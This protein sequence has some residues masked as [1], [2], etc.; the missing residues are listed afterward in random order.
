[1]FT[2]IACAKWSYP[3]RNCSPSRRWQPNASAARRSPRRF[4]R[5]AQTWQTASY[6]SKTQRQTRDKYA[7][8]R[9]YTSHVT[10][11]HAVNTHSCVAHH[12]AWLKCWCTLRLIRIAI[13]VCDLIVCSLLIP[14]LVLFSVFLLSL[15]LLPE[16]GPVPLHLPCGFHRGNI[17]LALRQM[18]SLALWPRTR[19][20]QVMSPTSSTISTTQ[21][22]LKSSSRSKPATLCPRTCMTRSSP[23]RPS[24]ERSLHHC[25]FSSEKTSGP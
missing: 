22:L 24:A 2:S 14:H 20:S 8:C 4:L 11:S 5:V 12:T 1:M 18:R 10:F 21:R 9:Q 19:L 16:S 3:Q 13:H 17:P 15:L 23:T 6:R 7:F 25:L